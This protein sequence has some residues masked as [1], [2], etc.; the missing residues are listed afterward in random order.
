MNIV[1]S[2][3]EYAQYK[4]AGKESQL[5]G[6]V[7]FVRSAAGEYTQPELPGGLELC[8]KILY[9]TDSLG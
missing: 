3:A 8:L 4:K 9:T 5:P 2:Q 1:T 7:F 6:P